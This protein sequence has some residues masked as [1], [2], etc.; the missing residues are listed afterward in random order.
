MLLLLLL[1]FFARLNF[2]SHHKKSQKIAQTLFQTISS[3]KF[4][5]RFLA[6]NDT[7]I[8]H[9]STVCRT[10]YFAET[11]SHI[12]LNHVKELFSLK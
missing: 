8:H 5:Y 9:S 10:T 2:Y 12:E 1:L 7:A 6:Q 3:T 11:M 4:S